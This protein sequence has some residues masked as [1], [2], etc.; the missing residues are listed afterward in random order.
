MA[1][2][3][4]FLGQPSSVAVD[5]ARFDFDM[6][7]GGCACFVL[8]TRP[9]GLSAL[10]RCRVFNYSF[11]DD[12][13]EFVVQLPDEWNDVACMWLTPQHAFAPTKVV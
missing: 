8:R 6:R 5:A 7:G 2:R 10:E 1:D 3:V 4:L 12:T 11:H 13:P 9:C